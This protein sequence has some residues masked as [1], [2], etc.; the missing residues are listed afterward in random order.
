MPSEKLPLD[1]YN[2][3]IAVVGKGNIFIPYRD[4]LAES[5]RT[6]GMEAEPFSEIEEAYAFQ[7]TAIVVIC[8]GLY[9]IPRKR[10]DLVWVMI[11]TEQMFT[12]INIKS[13]YL[14][15]NRIQL[16]PYLKAYDVVLDMFRENIEEERKMTQALVDYFPY[17]VNLPQESRPAAPQDDR[18]Y[19]LAFIGYPGNAGRREKILTYLSSRYRVFPQS[20]G[21]WGEEK[22]KALNC[23]KIYLNLHQDESRCM[24]AARM[25]DYFSHHCFVMTEPVYYS[26]PFA[27][28]EDYVSFFLNDVCQ[29]TD[30]YLAHPRERSQMAEHAYETLRRCQLKDVTKV[31]ID[32]LI[33]AA[34]K[35]T[36]KKQLSWYGVAFL[37]VKLKIKHLIKGK[38][39]E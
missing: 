21:L 9:K 23:A 19:D 37:T 13:V 4:A 18:E 29:K 33:I 5:I 16:K 24:E 7:P 1:Y 32:N 38:D 6:Y 22:E 31:L 35:K 11:Q 25:Y 27:D 20:V 3:K 17:A 2:Q 36:Q 28:G 39:L 26:E 15:R 10:K 8:P 30:Y 34:Y 12:K 14:Y